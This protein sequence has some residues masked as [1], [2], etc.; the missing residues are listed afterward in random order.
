MS[1]YCATS[2]YVSAPEVAINAYYLS[3]RGCLFT[4]FRNRKTYRVPRF[5]GHLP[6]VLRLGSAHHANNVGNVE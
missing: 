4:G 6:G 3:P 5:G 2:T 1:D